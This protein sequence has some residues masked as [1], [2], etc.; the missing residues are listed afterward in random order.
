[1]QQVRTA[2]VVELVVEGALDVVQVM[3]HYCPMGPP[4]MIV[5]ACKCPS[6]I[7]NIRPC[8]ISQPGE[9]ANCTEILLVLHELNLLRAKWGSRSL[10]AQ[11][12]DHGCPHSNL[13]CG[14]VVLNINTKEPV[15]GSQV[16]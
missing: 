4:C 6:S 9:L 11:T 16:T 8:T 1:M 7:G 2:S 15:G 12:R 14:A 10:Q 3:L 5:E 13:V